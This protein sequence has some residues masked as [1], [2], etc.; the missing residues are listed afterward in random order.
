M[1]KTDRPGPGAGEQIRL[2]KLTVFNLL[3]FP[4]NV[5]DR[6]NKKHHTIVLPT[7]NMVKIISRILTVLL[8]IVQLNTAASLRGSPECCT[9]H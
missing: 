7:S 8:F 1:W 4:K 9:E 2:K 6:L 5:L 3:Q